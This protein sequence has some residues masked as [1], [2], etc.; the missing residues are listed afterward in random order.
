[1]TILVFQA[2]HIIF[3][4]SWFAGLFYIV[5]LFIYFA[6]AENK[7]KDIQIILRDQYKIMQKR[8]W[9]I[10]TWPAMLLTLFFGIGMLYINPDYL[11]ISYMHI[12]LTFVLL[13]VIYHFLCHFIFLKQKNN[14]SPFSSQQLRIWN[15][16]ATLFLVS[17]VFIIVLKN[18]F[19]WIYGTIGFI[20]IALLLM[21]GIRLYKK[22]RAE[23]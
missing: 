16:I 14:V 17:I 18:E 23:K 1:M 2:L 10:I 5:R 9:Y 20:L 3:M 6:E 8:L 13:L 12:K 21:L 7:P 15:E 22:I 4:V 11:L 19:N